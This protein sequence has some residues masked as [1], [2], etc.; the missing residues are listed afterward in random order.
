MPHLLPRAKALYNHRSHAAAGSLVDDYLRALLP[1]VEVRDTPDRRLG[2]DDIIPF[3]GGTNRGAY[4]NFMH[5]DSDWT[6]ARRRG[7][8]TTVATIRLA[9]CSR[10]ELAAALRMLR[11]QPPELGKQVDCCSRACAPTPAAQFPDAAGF[12]M[13]C[14]TTAPQPQA[15]GEGNMFF[16][17][18]PEVHASEQP[19]AW[20]FPGEGAGG[21]RKTLNNGVWHQL[22]VLKAYATLADARLRWDY[23][24]LREGECAVFS[25]RTTHMTNIQVGEVVWRP[26]RRGPPKVLASLDHCVPLQAAPISWHRSRNVPLLISPP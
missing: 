22:Q 7:P 6:M 2:V 15:R 3:A 9:C 4:F 20:Q 12:Q 13:W 16:L 8:R 14:L 19:T 1:H 21:Y 18:S 25:K 10:L 5:W 24:A 26:V 11:Q 17:R 23:L